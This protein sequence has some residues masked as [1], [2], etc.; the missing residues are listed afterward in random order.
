MT[1][2]LKQ[3]SINRIFDGNNIRTVWDSE[4]EDCYFSVID[5]IEALTESS[6]PRRYWS[7]LK[8]KLNN[9]GSELYENI[10]QLKLKSTDGKFYST[11]TLNT[12]GI[13]RLIQSVPSP[14]AEPFKLWLAQVGSDRIDETF[15]PSKAI[16]RAIAIYRLQGYDDNCT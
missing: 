7:D 15:D 1:E 13:L 11:D 12:K 8:I 10:V 2:I 9:E 4:K 5:V 16:D 3:E 6:N 14:K